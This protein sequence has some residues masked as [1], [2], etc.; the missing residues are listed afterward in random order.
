MMRF[1]FK[2]GLVF[3]ELSNRWQLMRRLASGKLQFESETGEIKTMTD[4]DV[5]EAWMTGVWV[6]DE[7]TLGNQTDAIYLATPRDLSTFPEKWQKRARL[8]YHYIQKVNPEENKYNPILWKKLIRAAAAE[9]NDPTPPAASS[10]QAW[11]RRYRNTKSIV[12]LIPRSITGFDRGRDPRYAIFEDV[13]AKVY[14]TPQKLPKVDV[15]RAVQDQIYQ[16]NLGKEEAQKIAPISRSTVFRWLNE[17]QQD[18][19]DASRL[20]A[21]AAR[22][23]YRV[24]MGGLKVNEVLD[25]VEIDHTPLDVIVIDH[26]TMLP[27]GRPWLTLAIDKKSRMILGFYI[28]FNAPSSYSVLQ[29]LKRVILPKDKWLKRFPEISGTWPA[30]G[31]PRLIAVDNG[32]DL[33]SEAFEKSCQEL[34]IQILYCPAATPETKGSVERFFRSLNQG[35][36]HK[37]P[38]TVFSNIDERGDYP[39]EE[40]AA[41][42]METLVYLVTKWIVDVYSVSFHRGIQSTPLIK[43]LESAQHAMIDLPVYPQ[44]LDLI[45]GIPAKR[46]VFHYGVELEGLHYNSRAL[47]QLRRQAGENLQVQ[48]KFYM[49]TVGYIHVYDPYSKEYLKVEAVHEEYATNL[50]RETHRLVREHARRQ[51]GDQYSFVQLTEARQ[52]IQ[53]R[54]GEALKN[55]KMAQRKLGANVLLHDSEAVLAGETPLEVAH[56]PIRTAAQEPPAALPDGL[57]DELPFFTNLP[58]VDLGKEDVE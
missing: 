49:D 10:V 34:G 33:H 56:K 37:L 7:A 12:S 46:T 57:E 43:W 13:L 39:A 31:I 21:N 50:A 41:I 24:A 18:I 55:K 14:L 19:V 48:L 38:G 30:Y 11:W 5:H 17:L 54:I 6:I 23:K 42:D 45:T 1:S 32:M 52:A 15:V 53:D 9:I 36:I 8:R 25:R 4:S 3:V 58:S 16:L 44:Q 26:I 20:G 51:Y 28:S 22:A 47:Q 2:K 29:C 35:L 40:V 27:L